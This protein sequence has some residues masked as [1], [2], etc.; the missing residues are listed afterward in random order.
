MLCLKAAHP[1]L[2]VGGLFPALPAFALS[3]TRSGNFLQLVLVVKSEV[4]PRAQ[5]N[6]ILRI[7]SSLRS[8]QTALVNARR[9]FP[10]TFHVSKMIKQVL[11]LLAKLR[12]F[13]GVSPQVI[14]DVALVGALLNIGVVALPRNSA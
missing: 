5:R 8:S 6:M 3:N 9:Y 1:V 4:M 14:K 11:R 10:S 2:R 7:G 13:T 12:I